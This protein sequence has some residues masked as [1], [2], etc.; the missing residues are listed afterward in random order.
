MTKGLL[1]LAYTAYF[2]FVSNIHKLHTADLHKVVYLKRNFQVHANCHLYM[3]RHIQFL[4]VEYPLKHLKNTVSVLHCN[5]DLS[6]LPPLHAPH[7]GLDL[8]ATAL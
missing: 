4:P 5:T 8:V 2:T 1:D 3:F 7:W 6:P